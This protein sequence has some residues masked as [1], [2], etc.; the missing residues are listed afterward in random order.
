M[1]PPFAVPS[2]QGLAWA[3]PLAVAPVAEDGQ[4]NTGTAVGTASSGSNPSKVVNQ[5]FQSYQAW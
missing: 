2:G 4:G 5:I 3:L 1:P